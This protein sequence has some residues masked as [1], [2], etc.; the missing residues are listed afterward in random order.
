VFEKG[1]FDVVIGNP[2]YGATFTEKEIEF[3]NKNFIYQGY[4]LDSYLLFTERI[5]YWLK[6]GGMLG[7]IMPNTWLSLL[8][9]NKI[10][11]YIFNNTTILSITHYSYFVF[12][13]ATVETDTYILQYQ[14]P[15]N[16]STFEL[17]I[18]D[19][20]N[21]ISQRCVEQQKWINLDGG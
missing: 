4:Q 3:Y 8:F 19:K 14:K 12:E 10:R 2:P 5:G 1:G 16:N 20:N 17:S 18:V 7:Y 11:N 21:N 9:A 6:Q 15:E 13:D